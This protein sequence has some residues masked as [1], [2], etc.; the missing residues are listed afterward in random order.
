MCWGGGE[1][2]A[3]P[4]M[5]LW[6]Y[7][8]ICCQPHRYPSDRR[9]SPACVGRDGQ[10]KN[11][12]RSG[13][14]KADRPAHNVVTMPAKI[15]RHQMKHCFNVGRIKTTLLFYLLLM[16]RGSPFSYLAN[17]CYTGGVFQVINVCSAWKPRDSRRARK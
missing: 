1:G 17:S 2:G 12:C 3:A 4:Y 7:I 15:S 16:P 10:H 13:Y 11:A 9:L 14:L 5:K 8:Y 6:H